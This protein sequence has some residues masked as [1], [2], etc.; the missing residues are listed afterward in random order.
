MRKAMEPAP[1]R[2]ARELWEKGR[3]W[4]ETKWWGCRPRRR[5]LGW[6]WGCRVTGWPHLGTQGVGGIGGAVVHL[7]SIECYLYVYPI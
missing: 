2:R 1:A 4:R 7:L 3:R 5:V 6:D